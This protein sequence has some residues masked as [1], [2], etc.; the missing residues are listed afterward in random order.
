[1][2]TTTAHH[3]KTLLNTEEFL[4]TLKAPG[5]PHTEPSRSPLVGDAQAGATAIGT[6]GSGD[7]LS[8]SGPRLE[9]ALLRW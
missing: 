3:F 1:M 7:R 5:M 8:S 4:R 6:L 9:L 2:L